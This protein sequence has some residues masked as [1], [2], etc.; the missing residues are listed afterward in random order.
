MAAL[1]QMT[2]QVIDRSCNGY[3]SL[4]AKQ[5]R[6]IGLGYPPKKGWKH[7]LLGK[8]YHAE[9]IEKLISMK[10]KAKKRKPQKLARVVDI[11]LLSDK[12]LAELE[13]LENCPF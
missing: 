5:F 3:D 8:Y 10:K 4:T 1:I 9:D 11:D 7:R 13:I 6:F 12:E 2:Q